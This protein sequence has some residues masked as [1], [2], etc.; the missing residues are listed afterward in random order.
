MSPPPIVRLAS[1]LVETRSLTVNADALAPPLPHARQ[2][3]NTILCS[4]RPGKLIPAAIRIDARVLFRIDQ[5]AFSNACPI[6]FLAF[7]PW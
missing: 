7:C 4:A 1:L 6:V 3:P 2:G 5:E